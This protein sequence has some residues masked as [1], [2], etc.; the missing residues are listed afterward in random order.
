MCGEMSVA[1]TRSNSS[2]ATIAR[3]PMPQPISSAVSR[4]G[5]PPPRATLSIRSRSRR[6]D[7]QYVSQSV[8]SYAAVATRTSLSARASHV[9]LARYDSQ[10]RPS[11]ANRTRSAARLAA[12]A[13]AMARRTLASLQHAELELDI[14]ASDQGRQVRLIERQVP[15]QEA[16]KTQ[17]GPQ[18]AQRDPSLVHPK[19][20]LRVK[21][22]RA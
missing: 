6:P 5:V 1:I 22:V 11:T 3:R 14:R 7:A 9:R 21:A 15:I 16:R 17:L 2:A 20:R 19:A 12:F 8:A 13:A 10:R 4:P 18:R